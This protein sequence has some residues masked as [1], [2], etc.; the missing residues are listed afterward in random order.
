MRIVFMMTVA[1]SMV[2]AEPT[3][4]KDPKTNLVW[5][6]TLHTT[7]E[8]V[9]YIEAKAY[10]ETLSLG[11]FDNWRIP[12]LTELLSIVDY[13]RYKP[14]ALKEFKHVDN[15][16]LYWSSTAYAKSSTEYWGVVFKDGA[17]DDSSETYGRYVRCVRDIK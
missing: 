13:T 9:T 14:A 12:A 5:E 11:A 3:M 16:T 7:E 4:V 8:K 2:M 15:N 6:D 10:C 17:T 1:L